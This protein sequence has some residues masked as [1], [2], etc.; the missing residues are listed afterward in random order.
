L[1]RAY[2]GKPVGQPLK[3]YTA[4][5]NAVALGEIASLILSG[6]FTAD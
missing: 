1:G 6:F 5:L 3:G 4:G 2:T